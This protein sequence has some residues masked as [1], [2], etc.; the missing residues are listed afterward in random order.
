MASQGGGGPVPSLTASLSWPFQ[1]SP[2]DGKILNFGQVKNCE[3]EQ[4]K[5]VTY[6]L[7]S[8]L[9]PRTSAEDLPFPPGGSLPG[10]SGGSA[11]V[12]WLEGR[13]QSPGAGWG[14]KGR[15]GGGVGDAGGTG[16]VPGPEPPLGA[17][18]PPRSLCSG[19]TPALCWAAAG[20]C[21]RPEP[22]VR[23]PQPPPTAPSGTSWSPEKGTSST[24][25]SFTWPPGTT[26]ASTRP[27]TG[28]CPT[29][30]TSQVGRGRRKD[31]HG[32]WCPGVRGSRPQFRELKL[33]VEDRKR[34]VQGRLSPAHAV[35]GVT[36]G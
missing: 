11:A 15:C 4:V 26:T 5:G 25:V 3:V 24:T 19:C 30:A 21:L 22:H 13:A 20:A 29:G 12:W 1:I 34:T 32:P 28:P 35:F 2:S 27:L 8:F 23:A 18:G 7:E 9:G 31:E 6:S 14:G 10:Q 17:S 33:G 36:W 16:L